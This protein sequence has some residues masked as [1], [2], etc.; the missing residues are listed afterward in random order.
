[1]VDITVLVEE[2]KNLPILKWPLNLSSG[3]F[4]SVHVNCYTCYAR[5]NIWTFMLSI[6]RHRRKCRR[7]LFVYPCA[8][9]IP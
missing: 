6:K 7:P 8:R 3:A 5:K 1:L 4:Y 2:S 9:R